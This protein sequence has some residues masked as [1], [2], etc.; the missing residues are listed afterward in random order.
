MQMLFLLLSFFAL[1]AFILAKFVI[2]SNPILDYVGELIVSFQPY[3]AVWLIVLIFWFV[4]VARRFKK[5][6]IW[7]KIILTGIFVSSFFVYLYFVIQ[8]WNFYKMEPSYQNEQISSTW[9]TFWYANIYKNNTDYTWLLDNI[10]NT[11]PDVVLLV[12]YGL[13]HQ[14]FFSWFWAQHYPYR[15]REDLAKD[16]YGN[17]I[18]SKYP[19]TDLSKNI[20]LKPWRYGYVKVRKWNQ[21]YIL[22][23][24]HTSAPVSLDFYHQRID[25]LSW[26]VHNLDQQRHNF[27]NEKIVIIWDFNLSPRSRRYDDFVSKI[28]DNMQDYRIYGYPYFT[29]WLT[30]VPMFRSDIDHILTNFKPYGSIAKIKV[31]RSDHNWFVWSR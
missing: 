15:N 25:Q 1:I 8:V 5:V 31:K 19:L 29:R 4:S 10:K 18:F 16:Y 23:L 12:E 30:R 6:K 13:H 26:F 24:V 2:F 14:D 22:Y 20:D 11:D 27:Q 17:M 7:K 3:L 21:D 9:L 28:V